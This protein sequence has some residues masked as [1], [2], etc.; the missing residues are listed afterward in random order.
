[1]SKHTKYLKLAGKIARLKRDDR[2]YFLG[3]IGI[4]SDGVLVCSYNGAP[5]EPCAE[6]HCEF[7]LTRKLDKGSVVYI[8]RTLSDGTPALSKPCYT[9]EL[10]LR[11]AGVQRVYYTIS[12]DN[13]G[14]LE[15]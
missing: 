2:R 13:Y 6:H 9:C 11:S 4:R 14:V 7:R 1:M 12:I 5:K 10:A 8:S 15:L 3:A